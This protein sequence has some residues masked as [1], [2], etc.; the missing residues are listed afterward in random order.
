MAFTKKD[1]LKVSLYKVLRYPKTSTI[2]LKLSNWSDFLCQD[3][4]ITI[5]I[6]LPIFKRIDKT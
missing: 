3:F 5:T 2:Q 1:K 6:I 4:Y